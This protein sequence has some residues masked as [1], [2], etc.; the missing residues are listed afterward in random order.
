LVQ[1]LLTHNAD[2][3]VTEGSKRE[4][5]LHWAARDWQNRVSKKI[6]QLLL[7]HGADPLAKDADGHTPADLIQ[8]DSLKE[9][10]LSYNNKK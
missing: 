3:N 9:F 5:P 1:M 8:D 2:V 4:T 10:I 6:M 7:D